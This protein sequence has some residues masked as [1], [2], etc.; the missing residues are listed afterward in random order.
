MVNKI[1]EKQ[2]D[3][4]VHPVPPVF[5]NRFRTF[6]RST[7]ERVTFLEIRERKFVTN[8]ILFVIFAS[9]LKV[10]FL[11]GKKKR[12]R[13]SVIKKKKKKNR[14]GTSPDSIN[15]GI[16]CRE[17]T[18]FDR[19]YLEFQFIDRSH[20]L[21]VTPRKIEYKKYIIVCISPYRYIFIY[22]YMRIY[23]YI[24]FSRLFSR[25]RI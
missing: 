20:W 15:H 1:K 12:K 17:V 3:I 25:Y 14:K 18:S 8:D 6:D 13:A 23:I 16:Y 7:M 24:F 19:R 4:F 10:D 22:I 2:F 11:Y 5:S 21:R 9:A